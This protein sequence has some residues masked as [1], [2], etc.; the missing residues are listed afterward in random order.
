[1]MIARVMR[2]NDGRSEFTNNVGH[3]RQVPLVVTGTAI[4]GGISQVDQISADENAFGDSGHAALEFGPAMC[5]DHY[6]DALESNKCEA[7]HCQ[8]H[9][10]RVA[11]DK[12]QCFERK[13]DR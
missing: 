1:M 8:T 4:V 9:V 10:V 3:L 5:A 13:S 6:D 11:G 2:N 12:K 7:G